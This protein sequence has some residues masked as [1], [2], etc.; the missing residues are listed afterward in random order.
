MSDTPRND[1][2]CV[3]L[4]GAVENTNEAFV[5]IDEDSRVVFFNKAAE[6]IFGY[7]RKEVLGEDIGMLLSPMCESGHRQAVERYR[8][9]RRPVL[10]GHETELSVVRKDGQTFPASISFSVAEIGGRLFFTGIVRDLTEHKALQQQVLQ[11]ERLAMLGQTLAEIS[12]EIRNP[13]IMIGGFARQLLG[14]ARDDKDQAKLRIITEEVARL[15]RLLAGLR[16]LYRPQQLFVEDV[17]LAALLAEVVALVE[18]EAGRRGVDVRSH[19][20]PDAT[21]ARAD[22]EKLKQVILN[23][24]KNSLEALPDGGAITISTRHA[25]ERVEILVADGGEGIPE[26]VRRHVF[27]P[28]FTTKEQGTGLGLCISKRIIDDHPGGSFLLESR[29]GE[30]TVVTI[31]LSP[32]GN[33]LFPA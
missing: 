23:L 3:V 31:G 25:G 19:L 6:R 28:F 33:P 2:Q 22:R 11:T 13:L 26:E 32:C 17:D 5:T 30:G 21:R 4:K 7:R 12:H 10:I 8:E 24:V 15:E 14:K 1:M 29:E 16:D 18:D 9:T 20:A 27:S